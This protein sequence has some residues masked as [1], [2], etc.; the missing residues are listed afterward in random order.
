MTLGAIVGVLNVGRQI[1]D[2]IHGIFQPIEDLGDTI[3]QQIV[4]FVLEVM[5]AESGLEVKLD[6]VL[7]AQLRVLPNGKFYQITLALNVK[8]NNAWITQKYV[9][10]VFI[11]FIGH[12]DCKSYMLI[13]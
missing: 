3:I 10:E 1:S 4:K 7:S 2:G 5:A 8:V 6:A 11:P 12:W 13:N 9:F